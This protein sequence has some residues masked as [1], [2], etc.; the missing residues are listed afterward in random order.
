MSYKLL[1]EIVNSTLKWDDHVASSQPSRQRLKKAVCFLECAGASVWRHFSQTLGGGLT[2]HTHHTQLLLRVRYCNVWQTIMQNIHIIGKNIANSYHR[3]N[4]C[5]L[6]YISLSN[7][8]AVFKRDMV[9]NRND[10]LYASTEKNSQQHTFISRHASNGTVGKSVC[11]C[12]SSS[13]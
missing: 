9:K 1:N 5:W 12:H 10:T 7:M 2:F 8:S 4:A 13:G 11:V 3:R 6:H